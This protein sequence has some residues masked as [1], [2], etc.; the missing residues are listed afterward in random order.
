M[1]MDEHYSRLPV[2]LSVVGVLAVAT[3]LCAVLIAAHGQ[4]STPPTTLNLY[5]YMPNKVPDVGSTRDVGSSEECWNEAKEFLD[6]AP[7]SPAF[8]DAKALSVSC[9]VPLGPRT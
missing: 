9:L 1:I 5:V 6:K 8:K 3:I 2:L 7:R 4:E